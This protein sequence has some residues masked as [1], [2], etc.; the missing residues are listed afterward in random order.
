[1]RHLWIVLL[2]IGCSDHKSGSN[3][4]TTC[5]TSG[6]DGDAGAALITSV[7]WFTPTGYWTWSGTSLQIILDQH[8]DWQMTL[9]ASRTVGGDEIQGL[10]QAGAGPIEISLDEQTGGGNASVRHDQGAV[11]AAASYDGTL[12][13]DALQGDQLTACWDFVATGTAG[14]LNVTAGVAQVDAY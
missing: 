6:L 9:F 3:N 1:M 10:L 14:T 13:I 11:T 4:D 2:A 5:D 12:Y 7:D 8:I